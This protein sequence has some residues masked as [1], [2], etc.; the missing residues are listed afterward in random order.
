MTD[1]PRPDYGVLDRAGAAAI[2]FPRRDHSAAPDGATDHRLE[3]ESGVAIGARFYVRDAALPTILYFHG[4]GE[5]ASEHDDI[6]PL[7]HEIGCN[8]FVADF[9]GY[10]QSDGEPSMVHLVGDGPP[11]A[12]QFHEMLDAGGFAASRFIM[13]RSLGSQPALEIAA[14]A[15][16]GFQGL[17]VESGAASARRY[18]NRLGLAETGEA[19]TL[20]AAHEAKIRTITL[21]ALLIHGERDELVPLQQAVELRDLLANVDPQLVIIP[22]AGHN[23]LLWRGLREY[24]AA[25]DAM[26]GETS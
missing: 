9:R 24:F 5:V 12:E 25:I 7:Y 20:V 14:R 11:V 16:D 15:A 22:N 1:G 19:A 21:P 23:D 4:N 17:I 18:L 3:V 8:F 13:G 26:T 10:G 6:A 2:F